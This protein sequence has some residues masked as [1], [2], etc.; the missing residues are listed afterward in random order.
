[1][2][3]AI[4]RRPSLQLASSAVLGLSGLPIE[5]SFGRPLLDA[6]ATTLAWVVLFTSSALLVRAAFARARRRGT[7]PSRLEAT[8]LLA[9]S[10]AAVGCA[11][12]GAN[13]QAAALAVAALCF[14]IIAWGRSTPKQLK[15]L[16]V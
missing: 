12:T 9:T 15:R 7:P 11:L 2:S 16:G 3:P 14:S 10:A 4:R 13:P 5:L 6:L 8:A 1:M